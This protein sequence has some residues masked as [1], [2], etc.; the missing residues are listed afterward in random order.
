MAMLD[1]REIEAGVDAAT[2]GYRAFHRTA[3]V[4]AALAILAAVLLFAAF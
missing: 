3:F 4:L 2:R 1:E